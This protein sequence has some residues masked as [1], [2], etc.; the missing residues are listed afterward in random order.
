MRTTRPSS[1]GGRV[2]ILYQHLFSTLFHDKQSMHISLEFFSMHKKML[3]LFSI[4]LAKKITLTSMNICIFIMHY[5]FQLA[6]EMY[7]VKFVYLIIMCFFCNFSI[8]Y[9]ELYTC[10]MQHFF[11][12]KYSKK[13]WEF[14]EGKG[15]FPF[16]KTMTEQMLA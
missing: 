11:T 8:D 5:Q 12:T 16:H 2:Q 14:V 7:F 4:E 6:F 3:F 10:Q 13:T 1:I 9:A 15:L